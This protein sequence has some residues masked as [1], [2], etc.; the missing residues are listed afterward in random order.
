MFSAFMPP[1]GNKRRCGSGAQYI[2]DV[3]LA[4]VIGGEDFYHTRAPFPGLLY[5]AG[6]EGAGHGRQIKRQAGINDVALADGRHDK[7][8]TG[9]SDCAHLLRVDN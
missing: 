4:Q 6:G 2:L 5:L 7:L 9:V 1:V 8:C 3:T